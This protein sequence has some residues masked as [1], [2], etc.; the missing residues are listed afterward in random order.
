MYYELRPV[1][2]MKDI[3]CEMLCFLNESCYLFERMIYCFWNCHI[4]QLIHTIVVC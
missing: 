4:N 2:S 3:L 1:L